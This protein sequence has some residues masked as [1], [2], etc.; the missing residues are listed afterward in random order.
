MINTKFVL[1]YFAKIMKSLEQVI[2][3]KCKFIGNTKKSYDLYHHTY[4][5]SMDNIFVK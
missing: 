4:Y 5:E 2:K 1:Q 3:Q